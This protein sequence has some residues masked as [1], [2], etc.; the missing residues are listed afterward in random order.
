MVFLFTLLVLDSMGAFRWELRQGAARE[1]ARTPEVNPLVMGEIA[2][3][4]NCRHMNT[5]ALNR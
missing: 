5:S 2:Y 1:T 4:C 3:L